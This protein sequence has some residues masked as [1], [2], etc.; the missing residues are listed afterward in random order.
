M[1]SRQVTAYF[2]HK[3]REIYHTPEKSST[4]TFDGRREK[5]FGAYFFQPAVFFFTCRKF[6]VHQLKKFF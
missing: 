6:N 3:V 2:F 4:A 5:F 1:S